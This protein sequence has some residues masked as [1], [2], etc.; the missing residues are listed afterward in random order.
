MRGGAARPARGVARHRTASGPRSVP[1]ALTYLLEALVRAGEL[2]AAAEAAAELTSLNVASARYPAR[3]QLALGAYYPA[4]GDAGDASAAR[5]YLE[6]GRRLLRARLT[7]LAP[8]DAKA[9]RAL[10]FSRALL[11]PAGPGASAALR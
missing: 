1:H 4:A 7:A 3:V 11:R 8:E 9:Y 2:P 6:E 10:P 5:R